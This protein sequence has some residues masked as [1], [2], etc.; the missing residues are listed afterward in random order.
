[1]RE[2]EFRYH[3]MAEIEHRG[4]AQVLKRVL[5]EARNGPDAFFVSIDVSAIDRSIRS[6]SVFG[7]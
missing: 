5:R 6:A 1:M 4:A 3:T 2:N 7:Y